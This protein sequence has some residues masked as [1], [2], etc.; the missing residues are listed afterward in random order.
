MSVFD[1]RVA[2]KEATDFHGTEPD[3]PDDVVDL[4]ESD[5]LAGGAAQLV[6][7]CEGGA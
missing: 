3:I 1:S 5:V 2:F 7:I 4:L 6:V